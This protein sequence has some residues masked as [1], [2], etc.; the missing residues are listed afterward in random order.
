V[1]ML[2]YVIYVGVMAFS[3]AFLELYKRD[4]KASTG[5]VIAPGKGIYF[6]FFVAFLLAFLSGIRYEVGVDWYGYVTSYDTLRMTGYDRAIIDRWELGYSLINRFFAWINAGYQWMFFSVA[7]IGWGVYF[8]SIP[9]LLLPLSVYFL[10]AGELYFWSNNAVRQFVSAAFF[11]F[12]LK[13]I[14]E[15]KL[16]SYLL[17]LAAGALFH[18]SIL[19]LMPLYF[20][21]PRIPLSKILMPSV[22]LATFVAG[23][24]SIYMSLLAFVESNLLG[25]T[26]FLGYGGYVDRLQPVE[27]PD[28]GLGFYWIIFTN[29]III[30]LLSSA[31]KIEPY[32]RNVFVVFFV[33]AILFNLFYVSQLMGRI[34]VYFLF[35]KPILLAY[36]V[37]AFRNNIFGIL[38][39]LGLL[40]GYFVI[41]VIAIQSSSHQCC[42]YK[43]LL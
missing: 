3:V 27:L 1:V 18:I 5:V 31:H 2:T 29:L 39:K 43:W 32:I 19:I 22:M 15:R 28:L 36:I 7:L 37:I 21:A 9:Y 6:P 14:K 23:Q 16:L 26:S 8:R 30:T 35:V 20:I 13:F 40:I 11:V 12:S 4:C 41:Y 42:P 17:A 38:L 24:S 33:G 34:T 10:F 25:L